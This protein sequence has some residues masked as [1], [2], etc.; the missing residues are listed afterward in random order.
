MNFLQLWC[1]TNV[2]TWHCWNTDKLKSRPGAA[3]PQV[4]FTWINKI[5]SGKKST[6]NDSIYSMITHL[7]K[8]TEPAGQ[9]TIL[10]H[11][12]AAGCCPF[13]LVGK[14]LKVAQ[15]ATAQAVQ[16]SKRIITSNR[17][18]WDAGEDRIEGLMPSATWWVTLQATRWFWDSSK[19]T[20]RNQFTQISYGSWTMKH[21]SF[22]LWKPY[23][24]LSFLEGESSLTK[25]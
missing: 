2:M 12:P 6:G 17:Q 20:S 11:S 25:V 3:I 23:C 21:S 18:R 7:P 19:R 22:H 13:R 9:L 1:C 24:Q 8:A 16:T 14:E 4:P 10:N 15:K 5:K